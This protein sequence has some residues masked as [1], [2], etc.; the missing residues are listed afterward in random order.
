[1][2]S[3]KR[4]A[5]QRYGLA[6]VI[7]A[8]ALLI[9]WLLE[10]ALGSASPFLL[11][12]PAVMIS[13]WYGGLGPGLLSTLM[14]TLA[15]E[16]F[17]LR[18]DQSL[19][20]G[21]I[22]RIGVF[23][24]VALLISF[25]V[26]PRRRAER[27][28]A[29]SRQFL[30]AVVETSPSLVVVADADGRIQLFNRACEELTGYQREEVTGRTIAEVFWSAESATEVQRRFANPFAPE[31][32][33]PHVNPWVM[34][35]GQQRM[36]EWRCM[37]FLTGEDGRSLILAS[38]VDVTEQ[39]AVERERSELLAREQEARQQAEQANRIKDEF[40][41][42]VSHELRTPLTGIRGWADLLRT[43][44][45]DQ[46]SS[47]RALNSIIKNADMQSKLIDDLLD[48][49]R[50]LAGKVRLDLRP[51]GLEPV[52][53]MATEVVRPMVAAKRIQL[54]HV[55]NA[56]VCAVFG[57]PDRLQQVFLNLLTN[58]VKFTPEGGQIEV[59]VE[60]RDSTVQVSVSDTG[61]GIA[62]ETIP[63]VFDRFYQAE[64][65]GARRRGGLGLGLAIVRHIVEMHGGEV[66]A[67]SAGLG[68]GTT[69]RL[70]LPLMTVEA[71]GQERGEAG[72]TLKSVSP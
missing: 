69:M 9:R 40:L 38:G 60:R 13:A 31:L 63:H 37:P 16:W 45:L 19:T 42:T 62:A 72:I 61:K 51:V 10:P 8:L 52:I 6:I 67:E 22:A 68:Q 43:G 54:I 59:H 11:F 48:S 50:M 46:E 33:A 71:G 17:F 14:A 53:E 24:L 32:Q 39:L 2:I 65:R 66:E 35:S 49:S 26:I 57:D 23:L 1:M 20:T 36:I 64:G 56:T 29:E 21:S 15:G 18:P 55:F 47:E 7:T 41:A 44:K 34:K 27:A 4:T 70:T 30:Q 3:G 12:A 58:A 5:T 25:L 28:L